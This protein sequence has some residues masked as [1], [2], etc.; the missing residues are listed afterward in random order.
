MSILLI[1]ILVFGA[2]SVTNSEVIYQ[3]AKQQLEKLQKQK[4]ESSK[5]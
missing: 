3:S 4:D 2:W 1:S 5:K